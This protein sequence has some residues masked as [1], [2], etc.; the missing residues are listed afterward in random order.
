M[1]QRDREKGLYPYYGATGIIDY[2]KEFI[3]DEKL[4]LIG[5]D[6]AKWGSNENS[7]FIA[8]G[9]YWV[10]NH[11]H[12]L[13]PNIDVILDKF[14]VEILNKFDLSDYI[15]GMNVPKLNQANLNQIQIPLPPKNIQEK[16]VTEIEVLEVKE[17]KTKDE[18]EKLNN[19]INS[20]FDIV[21][22]KNKAIEQLGNIS[23]IKN[24]GTPSSND[25]ELWNGNISWATLVDT[26]EKYLTKTA[27]TISQ[28]GLEKS[29]AVLLPINTVLFS[30]RATIG[31]VSIAKIEVCTNQGYKNFICDPKKINYEYLYYILKRE[32]KNIEKL[33]SGMT[34]LEISK[35]LISE[36]KIPLPTIQE[37]QKIVVQI[38]KIEGQI[39]ELTEELQE[40]KK[41]KEEVLKKYL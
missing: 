27:R 20:I 1:S 2:V 24:G 3:F 34:Y 18:V 36:Y 31:D 6:G 5:E 14:L 8:E 4:V 29:S 12:V 38:Q 21:Y 26:K 25:P 40:I 16:I 22:L 11:A 10:N 39:F 35:T 15:T 30:S 33:G 41:Q 32:A 9:K 23:E 37:Q 13:K 7:A 19:E 28:K 17:N